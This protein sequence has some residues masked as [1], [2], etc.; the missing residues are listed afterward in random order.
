M[1]QK[2][3]LFSAIFLAPALLLF[4]VFFIVPVIFSVYYS[5]TEWDAVAKPEF[6]GIDNF[7]DLWKDSDYWKSMRNTLWLILFAL[8]IKV[9]GGL[10]LAY[11][12]LRV[13]RGFKFFRTVYFL[14]VVIAPMAI[15]LM[16]LLIY[17][18]NGL[19]NQTLDFLGLSSLKLNWLSNTRV[20]M[21]A[22][23]VPQ[24]W[25]NIGL[26][27]IIF[28]A[29]LQSIPR[30]IFE[31]AE[32]DGASSVRTLFS[33]VIPM[34]WDVLQAC[35]ILGVTGALKAFDIPWAITAGGP[36]VA[37]AFASVYLFMR[38]FGSYEF[39]YASAI[40]VTIAVYALL[41]TV[42]FKRFFSSKDTLE[43]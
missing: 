5:L 28:L 24:T 43:Y 10:V 23:A 38:S 17:S 9:S 25:Q 30:E 34:L 29:A 32:I 7:S 14:P 11:L 35:I 33:I 13:T 36:G 6:I 37:S 4:M 42:L 21:F 2:R 20:V 3:F 18:D 26:F 19:L 27:F 39:G 31:S 41:F 8:T 40:S 15:G 12:L 1:V 16:F 22:V